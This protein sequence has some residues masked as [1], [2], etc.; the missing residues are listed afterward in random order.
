MHQGPPA[1]LIPLSVAAT[2]AYERVFGKRRTEGL[3]P[4]VDELDL[5]ALALSNHL[6]LYGR[7]NGR[8]VEI[9]QP[10]LRTGMFWGG[11]R[12]FENHQGDT[13]VGLAV[14]RGALTATLS[15]ISLDSL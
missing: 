13:I 11:A 15:S 4:S 8:T 10:D 1:D 3:K 5:V 2:I 14:S 9:P 12:R 7:V 6:P